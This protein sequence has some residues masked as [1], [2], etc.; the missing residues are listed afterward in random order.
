MARQH[1]RHELGIGVEVA[2]AD[3]DLAE[4]DPLLLM[5][6]TNTAGHRRDFADSVGAGHPLYGCGAAVMAMREEA[7]GKRGGRM[8]LA[9][10]GF[11]AVR[12]GAEPFVQRARAGKKARPLRVVVE[13]GDG[14]WNEGEQLV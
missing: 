14:F 5:Q 7:T 9:C 2:E 6:P 4:L 10:A 3:A 12:A 13:Q 8:L 11:D 1:F